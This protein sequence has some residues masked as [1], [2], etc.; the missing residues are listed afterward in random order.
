MLSFI[1][2]RGKMDW[3]EY[4]VNDENVLLGKTTFKDTG[5]SVEHIVGL[6]AQGWN[7]EQILNNY[8]RLTHE[9]MQALFA[10]LYDC[11]KDGLLYP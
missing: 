11:M 1:K 9:D 2:R 10:F 8:P 3:T 7:E 4:I 6:L 5:I